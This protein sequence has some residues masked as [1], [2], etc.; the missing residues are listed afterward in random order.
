MLI[1]TAAD[2]IACIY[3]TISWQIKVPRLFRQQSDGY[4]LVHVGSRMGIDWSMSLLL[5]YL[6]YKSLNCLFNPSSTVNTG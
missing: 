3:D 5:L 6:P 4:R 2:D 1:T